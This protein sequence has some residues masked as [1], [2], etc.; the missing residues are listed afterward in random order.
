MG[1]RTARSVQFVLSYYYY[2]H[3]HYHHHHH[4][5]YYYYYYSIIAVTHNFKIRLLGGLWMQPSCSHN[6]AVAPQ[7]QVD[8]EHGSIL[9]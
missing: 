9:P 2:H 1:M 3:H 5:Y 8:N 6:F 7:T 4:H